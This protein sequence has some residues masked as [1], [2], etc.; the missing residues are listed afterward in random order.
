MALHSLPV[1]FLYKKEMGWGS[2]ES[3]EVCWSYILCVSG[4]FC[5]GQRETVRDFLLLFLNFLTLATTSP[6]PCTSGP[7]NSR[8]FNLLCLQ[9]CLA[10][11]DFVTN[12]KLSLV[13]VNLISNQILH[14]CDSQLHL[15]L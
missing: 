8:R 2:R 15:D 9:N 4:V 13:D 1:Y 3:Q 5:E 10:S 12:R 11:V 7:S 6:H 14:I